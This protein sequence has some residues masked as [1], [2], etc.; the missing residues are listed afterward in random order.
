MH[1]SVVDLD[2]RDALTLK[3]AELWLEVGR[4]ELALQEVESLGKHAL[5]HAWAVRVLDSISSI[6]SQWRGGRAPG[7][8]HA[9]RASAN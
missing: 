5:S 1:Y 7:A 3:R 4:V 2:I 8:L 9:S 6:C